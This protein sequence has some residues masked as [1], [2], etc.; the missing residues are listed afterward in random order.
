MSM[1]HC[2]WLLFETKITVT[3]NYQYLANY[4]SLT[5]CRWI[6]FIVFW[7]QCNQWFHCSSSCGS[8]LSFTI[9]KLIP[10]WHSQLSYFV[11]M[12]MY[13]IG[14]DESSKMI[15]NLASSSSFAEF[16]SWVTKWTLI[17]QFE[18]SH[19]PIWKF[20]TLFDTRLL[21]RV[22]NT[23]R[24]ASFYLFNFVTTLLYGII[25]LL[26]MRGGWCPYLDIAICQS[27][28]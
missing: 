21:H 6:L 14:I 23:M 16:I 27:P 19:V 28:Y 5:Y 3:E 2:A 12:C 22:K 24:F 8:V 10:L 13:H 20:P 1:W 4:R 11:M 15:G 25:W 7:L 26:Y 9:L 17:Q 18:R